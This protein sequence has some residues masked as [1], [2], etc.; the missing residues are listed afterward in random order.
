MA[1]S[2]QTMVRLHPDDIAFLRAEGER[3][4]RFLDALDI[5]HRF[6]KPKDGTINISEVHRAI[7][8]DERRAK[9]DLT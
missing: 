9:G 4:A 1:R 3:R 6:R 5:K 7:I 8:R 2:I